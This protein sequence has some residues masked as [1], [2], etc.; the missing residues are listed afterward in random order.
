MDEF[1]DTPPDPADVGTWEGQD[2]KEYQP[3]PSSGKA[4]DAGAGGPA[5]GDSA[6][7]EAVEDTETDS[8]TTGSDAAAIDHANAGDSTTSTGVGA[9]AEADTNADGGTAA[10]AAAA[11]DS[12][13]AD[14]ASAPESAEPGAGGSNTGTEIAGASGASVTDDE[15]LVA[16]ADADIETDTETDTDTAD[17]EAQSEEEADADA[18]ADA[19]A[20]AGADT[21]AD[22][23]GAEDASA[24]DMLRSRLAGVV[25][26]SQLIAAAEASRL[27][28]IYA[29][30]QDALA[31]PGIFA[32]LPADSTPATLSAETEG[33]VRSS[34]AQEIGAAIGVTKNHAAGLVQDAEILCE[35]LPA[36]LD[37]LEDGRITRQHTQAM[38]RQ[39]ITLDGDAIAMFEQAAL[40]KAI[41]QSPTQFSRAVVSIREGLFPETIARRRT[42]AVKNRRVDC[43]PAQDGMGTLAVHA[44]I[45]IVQSL[46]NAARHTARALKAAGDDRTLAQI[47]TDTLIDAIMTGFTIDATHKPGVGP[48]GVGA[49]RLGGIRPTVYVTV[50]VMTLLGKSDEPA[51][52]DGYGPIDPETAR[53][54][55][56]QAPSFTRLLTHPETGAVLS[57]GRD[58]YAVPADLKRAVQLRDE[59]CIGI[60]CDRSATSCDLDHRH[61][62]Q[63]GGETSYANLQ[64]VCEQHHMIRHHTQWQA[65]LADNGHIQ[66]ISPL[67]HTYRVPRTSNVQFVHV[68]T[69]NDTTGDTTTDDEARATESDGNGTI[70]GAPAETGFGTRAAQ[71]GF[72]NT[73][74]F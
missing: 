9:A 19:G 25:D 23:D 63:D 42:D 40:P 6:Y 45:E 43:Y 3:P 11:D 74:P 14:K 49:D 50:P 47:E 36:T 13:T 26:D 68:N 12:V 57:V 56:A 70:G 4:R 58:S 15:S 55:A 38:I 1:R 59:T 33:W 60:G 73:P 53:I 5:R 20:D 51:H 37:A 66:W 54:L 65:H 28:G 10:D 34:L 64:S 24:A 29:M 18:D 16:K 30:L 8:D 32:V 69:E 35:D 71:E 72:P 31:H 48:S 52:L 44:P 2:R 7:A 61:E 27:R 41:G 21:G 39:A 62:W 22:A 46:H 17:A 67:G